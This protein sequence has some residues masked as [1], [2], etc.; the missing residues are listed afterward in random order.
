MLATRTAK[1]ERSEVAEHRGCVSWGMLFAPVLTGCYKDA[2]R[3]VKV[4]RGLQKPA[5]AGLIR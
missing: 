3:P 5:A 4:S 2:P 1:P